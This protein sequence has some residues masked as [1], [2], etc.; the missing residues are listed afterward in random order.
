MPLDP[1]SMKRTYADAATFALYRSQDFKERALARSMRPDDVE[2][3]KYA[4]LY[5]TGGH[6]VMWDFPGCLLYTSRLGKA[7]VDLGG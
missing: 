7:L 6:G 2:A 1:R 5:Y 3:E 4:A